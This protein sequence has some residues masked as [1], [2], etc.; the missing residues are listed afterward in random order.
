MN[1]FSW[2]KNFKYKKLGQLYSIIVQNSVKKHN[3]VIMTYILACMVFTKR[4]K[5]YAKWM[6]LVSSFIWHTF[7]H[8]SYKPYM[9]KIHVKIM[10]STARFL[11]IV[12]L[13][14]NILKFQDICKIVKNSQK[15]KN[16][17]NYFITQIK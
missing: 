7:F 5:I 16:Y 11:K 8:V 4:R 10:L 14:Q 3:Y 13:G 9:P 17:K 12:F 1:T 2:N 15:M 6:H